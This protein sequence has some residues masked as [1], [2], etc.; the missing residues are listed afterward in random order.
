VVQNNSHWLKIRKKA[1]ELG[2][3]INKETFISLLLIRQTSEAYT[4]L[5]YSLTLDDFAKFNNQLSVSQSTPWHL[6]ENKSGGNYVTAITEAIKLLELKYLSGQ[7]FIDTK[8]YSEVSESVLEEFIRL[9]SEIS[10]DSFSFSIFYDDYMRKKACKTSSLHGDFYTPKCI[11]QCMGSLLSPKTGSVY[12]PCCGSGAMLLEMSKLIPNNQGLFG[13]TQNIQSYQ[14]CYANAMLHGVDIDLG[15]APANTLTDDQHPEKIF[16]YIIAN[17]PFNLSNWYE[18]YLTYGDPRWR[19]GIPPRSNANF[20]WLQHILYHLKPDGRAAVILPNSTLTGTRRTE[21]KIRKALISDGFVEA[22]ITFPPGI[23]YGTKVPF[24]LW[25]I[26]K[27]TQKSS[28]ILFIDAAKLNPRVKKNITKENCEQIEALVD[29]FRKGDLSDKTPECAAASLDEVAQKDFI[30][31][32]N[33]YTFIDCMQSSAMRA[34]K[35]YLNETIS[36]LQSLINDKSLCARLEKWKRDDIVSSWSKASLLELYSVFGGLQK[37]K[38]SFKKGQPLLDVR[39]IIHNCFLPGTLGGCMEVS[40]EEAEKYS[41]KQGDVLLNRTSE[42][43]GE[44]ACCCIAEKDSSA[45]YSSFVK[46]LRPINENLIYPPYAAGY[47]RSAVYRCEVDKV[48]TVYTTYASINNDK[49]N[50]ISFYYPDEHLQREIGDTLLAVFKY[51]ENSTNPEQRK[52]LCDFKSL[53]IEQ[54]IT[55]PITYLRE[56]G[57]LDR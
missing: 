44:L 38:E 26:N 28:S 5:N 35:I 37:G 29:K 30:L 15:K 42:T 54:Y 13:Q 20:A 53:L 17:P 6:V 11:I 24:C 55:Y 3:H 48:S 39:S 27:S 36:G 8:R 32:P 34:N 49:L 18:E 4:P 31:S 19:Y 41:I 51:S 45:V 47:F 46:R 16:D 23:F 33:L 40:T 1:G 21:H 7:K 57:E 10:P 2:N 9:L 14:T 12:D 56:K 25:L 43:I 22:I 50:A 52:L